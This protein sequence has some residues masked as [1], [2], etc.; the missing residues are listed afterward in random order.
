[1]RVIKYLLGAI[2]YILV[3]AIM[4]FIQYIKYLKRTIKYKGTWLLSLCFLYVIKPIWDFL[5][6]VKYCIEK[7]VKEK[8]RVNKYIII[9]I[10]YIS[11]P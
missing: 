8:I 7:A 5:G 11:N 3:G 1:V 4:Y 10:M 2:K 9:I 6:P